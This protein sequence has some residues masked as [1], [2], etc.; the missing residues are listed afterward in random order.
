MIFRWLK[1]YINVQPFLFHFFKKKVSPLCNTNIEPFFFKKKAAPKCFLTVANYFPTNVTVVNCF[2]TVITVV[3][4]FPTFLT[5]RIVVSCLSTLI[6]ANCFS[7]VV[8]VV[9]CFP[10]LTMREVLS[11]NYN[12]CEL[13]VK[14]IT[15]TNCFP[16]G[17][18]VAN[19]FPILLPTLY[20]SFSFLF[21]LTLG[22]FIHSFHLFNVALTK[23]T[24]RLYTIITC[25]NLHR[26]K[27][28]L[29]T[30]KTSIIWTKSVILWIRLLINWANIAT[31]G[32]STLKFYNF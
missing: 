24:I 21:L 9:K 22:S 10:T 15:V 14:L 28:K 20:I 19:C 4:C 18:A 26:P 30:S 27:R 17:I 1:G 16:T 13:L 23:F 7:T 8:T 6:A 25:T 29:Q 31:A 2:S 5:V 32:F 12:C 11:D 3:N